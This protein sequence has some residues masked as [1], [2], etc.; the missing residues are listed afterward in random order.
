M[1]TPTDATTSSTGLFWAGSIITGL[2]VLFLVFDAVAKLAK[3]APVMEA[4]AQLGLP[5]DSVV[6]IGLLL[7]V[8]TILY[9]IPQTAVLG[10]ILLTGYLGGA[11]AIHLRAGSGTFPIVFSIGFGVLAWVGLFLREPRLFWTVLLR[12]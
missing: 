10:A 12:Q 2:T 5:Q 7:L 3:V 8:C 6:G 1:P 4:T 11:A 9:C